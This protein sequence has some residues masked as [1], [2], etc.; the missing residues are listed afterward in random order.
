MYEIHASVLP[1]SPRSVQ[2]PIFVLLL[3]RALREFA[4]AVMLRRSRPRGARPIKRK[5]G[6]SVLPA[7]LLSFCSLVRSARVLLLV[8][9][10]AYFASARRALAASCPSYAVLLPFLAGSLS[11]VRF[12]FVL[13]LLS[14]CFN[15]KSCILRNVIA[16][17]FRDF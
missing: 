7:R 5:C 17:P 9:R 6:F 2:L 1:R 15:F 16:V 14:L 3:V 4:F 11:S 13:P 12:C 8:C 10:S